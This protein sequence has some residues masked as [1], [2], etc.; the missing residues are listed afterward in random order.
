MIDV[1]PAIIP[2]VFKDIEGQVSLVK[3]SVSKVQIDISDGIFSKNTTWPFRNDTGEWEK[4]QN[5]EIGLPFWD[6]IDYEFHLMVEDPDT[7]ASFC[8][9]AGASSIV[10]HIEKIKDI[11][12]LKKMCDKKDVKLIIAILPKTPLSNL[13]PFISLCNGVQ[14]MGSN[15]IGYHGEKIDEIVYK[16]IKELRDMY[17][18]LS[19]G[20]DIGVTEENAPILVDAGVSV[21]VAGSLIFDSIDKTE[22]IEYLKDL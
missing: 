17:P 12:S 14:F 10:V 13:L 11:E 2:R 7:F 16:K 15:R 8:I 6:D 3:N 21:F 22:I 18:D 9:S 5:E 19:I 4:L 20:I 1:I